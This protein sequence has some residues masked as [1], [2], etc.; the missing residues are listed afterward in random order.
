MLQVIFGDDEHTAADG[1]YTRVLKTRKWLY[2]TSI[3]GL[4]LAQGLYDQDAAARLI[5]VVSLPEDILRQAVFGATAYL[6]TQY[7]FLAVQLFTTYDIIIRERLTFRREDELAS[8]RETV[9]LL[10]KQLREVEATSFEEWAADMHQKVAAAKEAV[11]ASLPEIAS[12]SDEIEIAE[13]EAK[14][15]VTKGS[16]VDTATIRYNYNR[17]KAQH[18]LRAETVRKLTR[19]FDAGPERLDSDQARVVRADLN[20]AR[21][22]HATLYNDVPANRRGYRLFE[23]LIDAGRILPPAVLAAT[24]LW[25]LWPF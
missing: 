7:A 10:T 23:K 13:A 16:R 18:A 22:A 20:K 14:F 3:A 5:S 24:A 15:A 12:L 8:A 4:L 6:S 2:L 25:Q 17:M 1:P 19:D 21:D 11:D 9:S